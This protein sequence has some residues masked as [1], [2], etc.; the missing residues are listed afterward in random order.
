MSD[1]PTLFEIRAVRAAR[2]AWR[3]SECRAEIQVGAPYVRHSGLWDGE[4]RHYSLCPFCHQASQDYVA[5][6]E[7]VSALAPFDEAYFLYTQLWD[8]IEADDFATLIGPHAR[9]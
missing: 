7:D 3:C 5:W 2:R 4:Y 6:L 9:P 1:Q 8:A